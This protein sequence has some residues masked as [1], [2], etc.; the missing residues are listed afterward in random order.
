M[1]S[2]ANVEGPIEGGRRGHA[3][4]EV[5]RPPPDGHRLAVVEQRCV[6]EVAASIH[7]QPVGA[8]DG[9]RRAGD[10]TN[11]PA[12]LDSQSDASSITTPKRRCFRRVSLIR[13]RS[14]SARWSTNRTPGA[15]VGA[16]RG[17]PAPERV[18]TE[19]SSRG[20]MRRPPCLPLPSADITSP[21]PEGKASRR[22][23]PVAAAR[24]AGVRLIFR[25]CFS[26]RGV[27]EP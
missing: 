13:F 27:G 8:F 24:S 11:V 7:P 1:R 2:R 18:R 6:D 17:A 15:G 21:P 19:A 16:A 4:E 20:E 22:V 5:G 12:A 10:E 25:T 14:A 9:D 26:P 3:R 23:R